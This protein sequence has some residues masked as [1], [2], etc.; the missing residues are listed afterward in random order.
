MVDKKTDKHAS[1]AA[2][3][4]NRWYLGPAMEH[5]H[6]YCVYVTNTRAERKSD[7]MEFFLQHT[8]VPSMTA[9]NAATTAAQQ[10]VTA[11][12]NPKPQGAL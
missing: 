8:K 4:V 11:L 2:H 10:L 6:C 3:G 12:S 7:T 5:Y 9:I 1:W